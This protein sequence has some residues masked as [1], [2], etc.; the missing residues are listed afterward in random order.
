MKNKYLLI[1]ILTV[2]FRFINLSAED[3]SIKSST[4]NIDKTT[5]IILFK[6]DVSATDNKNNK[7]F[8]N[9]NFLFETLRSLGLAKSCQFS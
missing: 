1:T 2:F 4:I 5:K 7:F 6:G 9:L 8:H 3:L